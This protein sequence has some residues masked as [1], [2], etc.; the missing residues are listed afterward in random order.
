M[1]FYSRSLQ[2]AA[3]ILLDALDEK[4]NELTAWD[5]VP[6]LSLYRATVEIHLKG[7]VG[8]GCNFLPVPTDYISIAKTRSLRWLAQITCQIIRTLQWEDEFTCEGVESLEAF[9]A[10]VNEL[11]MLDPVPFLTLSAARDGSVPR[12]LQ[13]PQIR[14]LAERL[15]RLLNLL[16]VTAD[17]LAATRDLEEQGFIVGDGKSKPTIH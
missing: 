12:P 2:K 3:K 4:P 16:S 9:G 15:D 17:T 14:R 6:I 7:L 1:L 8:E 5:A 10:L 11:E 13:A